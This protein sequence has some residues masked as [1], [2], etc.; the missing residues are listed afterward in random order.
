MRAIGRL[1][2]AQDLTCGLPR[3]DRLPRTRVQQLARYA[4]TV[5]AQTIMRLTDERRVAALLAF[6][7]TREATATDDVLDLFDIVMTRMV[8]EAEKLREKIRQRGARD[9]DAAALTLRRA[10]A[11][12][13]ASHTH[14][15]DGIAARL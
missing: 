15:E 14:G 4:N 2:E 3:A 11:V 13:I 6:I 7:T 5:D 12:A 10:G 1:K 8:N 9:L